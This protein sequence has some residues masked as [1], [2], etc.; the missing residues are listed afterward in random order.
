MHTV[1]KLHTFQ[2]NRTLKCKSNII[3]AHPPPRYDFILPP[4]R[5]CYVSCCSKDTIQHFTVNY[6]P[7]VKRIAEK[8]FLVKES[9]KKLK[10]C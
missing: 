7:S 2:K 5:K 3:S 1:H 4:S 6:S 8:M 10:K 9:E